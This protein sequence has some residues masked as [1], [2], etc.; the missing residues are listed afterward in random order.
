MLR[1][2][3]ALGPLLALLLAGCGSPPAPKVQISP[4]DIARQAPAPIQIS[5]RVAAIYAGYLEQIAPD[6]SGAFAISPNGN[7]VDYRFCRRP[8][9]LLSDDEVATVIGAVNETAAELGP[10]EAG[11]AR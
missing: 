1:K 5:P 11:S 2:I 7:R 6:V 9:C 4:A 8:D 3:A 10:I